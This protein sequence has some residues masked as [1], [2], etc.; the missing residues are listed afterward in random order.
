MTGVYMLLMLRHSQ[1]P[2]FA[3]LTVLALSAAAVMLSASRY[4]SGLQQ[5]ELTAFGALALENLVWANLLL[6][7][8]PLW[9]RY[10]TRLATQLHWNEPA[11]R[12]P[13]LSSALALGVFWLLGLLLWDTALIL[14][15]VGST[16]QRTLAVVLGVVLTATLIHGFLRWRTMTAVHIFLGAAF[17]TVLAVW[18]ITQPFHLPLVLVLWSAVLAAG[19]ARCSG[20]SNRL[21]V[22]L[23][24]ALRGWLPVL[25]SVGVIALVA[26]PLVAMTIASSSSSGKGKR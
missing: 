12:T 4:E 11:L 18:G 24:A 19:W 17:L 13:L 21:T 10:G 1:W 6:G 16:P 7:L 22:M 23:G 2:G 14:T 5:A 3:W 15:G 9:E 25:P 20:S 26:M 8:V